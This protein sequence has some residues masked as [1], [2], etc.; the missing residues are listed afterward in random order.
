[1]LFRGFA[2]EPDQSAAVGVDHVLVPVPASAGGESALARAA[3]RP[4][5]RLWRRLGRS[6][7]SRAG[8]LLVPAVASAP[9]EAGVIG[10]RAA[11]QTDRQSTDKV[12]RM[13]GLPGNVIRSFKRLTQAL[14]RLQ[15]CLPDPAFMPAPKTR[16]VPCGGA[17][18]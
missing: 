11:G 14:A 13:S 5:K 10:L 3:V 7:S 8:R 1:V 12:W 6:R 2:R 18:R 17:G 16:G 9:G 15:L 4:A